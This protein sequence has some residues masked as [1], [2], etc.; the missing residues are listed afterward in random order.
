MVDAVIAGAGIAGI[1]TAWQLAE[2]LGRTDAVI[3]DPRPPLS[4]TSNRPEANYR[5]WWPQPAMAELADMSLALVDELVADGATIPMDRRGYLYVTGDPARAAE[6]RRIVAER[7]K[8]GAGAEVLDA[9]AARS[10]YRHLS[11]AIVAGILVHRAGSLDTVALGRAMLDR[12]LARGVAVVEGDVLAV[13]TRP[14]GLEVTFSTPHGRRA[15]SA[16]RFVNAAGPFARELA[17]QLGED[18]PLETVLRQKVMIEDD[19]TIVPREAPFTIFL[20]GQSLAWTDAERRALGGSAHGRRL[21]GPLPGGIHVKPDENAGPHAVK[22]GWAW[23]QTPMP[24]EPNPVCPPEFPRMA[25]LGASTMIPGLA[26]YADRPS[27][28]AHDG[29]FYGRA[30]DGQPLIGPSRAGSFVVAG[31]AGFGAMMATGAGALAAAWLLG[32]EPTPLMRA[33]DPARFSDARHVEAI[34]A[35]RI[36]TGEL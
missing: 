30:P 33:F 26:R 14:D 34:E 29:G 19:A 22:L 31:L 10:G 20:D 8:I 15:L 35:G 7:P 12:A 32:D 4:L 5:D 13:E 17:M 25:L 9:T 6:L 16:T 2:R 27:P 28:T 23:D 36:A 3:V 24:P 21:L 1:A 11:P 18:L